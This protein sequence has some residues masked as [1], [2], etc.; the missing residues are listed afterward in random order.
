MWSCLKWEVKS[1]ARLEIVLLP[2]NNEFMSHESCT[3]NYLLLKTTLPTYH[4]RDQYK[5]LPVGYAQK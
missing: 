5:Q 3:E 4:P 2:Y 1:G